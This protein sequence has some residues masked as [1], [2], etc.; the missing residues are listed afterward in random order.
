MGLADGGL[1]LFGVFEG[2][3]FCL[4]IGGEEA[5]GLFSEFGVG[6][7]ELFANGG[8]FKDC[9][10]DGGGVGTAVGD[11]GLE[12]LLFGVHLIG[13][14]AIGGA[15]GTVGRRDGGELGVGKVEVG[16]Q[17]GEGGGG[18]RGLREADGGGEEGENDRSFHLDFFSFSV[19]AAGNSQPL[20]R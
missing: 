7:V 16:L 18:G 6:G 1:E 8:D 11:G 10:A 4:L 13:E 5:G 2:F 20:H 9:L 12:G 17:L 19:R 3:Q 14:G 15:G